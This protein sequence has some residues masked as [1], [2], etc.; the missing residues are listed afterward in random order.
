MPL[1][2]FWFEEFSEVR[3]FFVVVNHR[4]IKE[5]LFTKESQEASRGIV[6]T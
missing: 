5:S 1:F 3:E 6:D 2:K 4:A